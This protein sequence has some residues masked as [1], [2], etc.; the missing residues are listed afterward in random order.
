VFNYT[1]E[2][3]SMGLV[4][5][6]ARAYY[7]TMWAFN[8]CFKLIFDNTVLALSTEDG[9]PAGRDAFVGTPSSTIADGVDGASDE[10]WLTV[11]YPETRVSQEDGYFRFVSLLNATDW[12]KEIFGI[13]SDNTNSTFNMMP[14]PSQ[15]PKPQ[16]Y[17]SIGKIYFKLQPGKTFDDVDVKSVFGFSA[18]PPLTFLR[19]SGV[20]ISGRGI[21]SDAWAIADNGVIVK[22]NPPTGGDLLQPITSVALNV[23][24]PTAGQTASASF[25]GANNFT[26]KLSWVPS[27]STFKPGTVYTATATLTAN[28]GYTFKGLMPSNVTVNGQPAIV[29]SNSGNKLTIVYAFPKTDGETSEPYKIPGVNIS[30]PIND[31]SSG[32][33][34]FET[35]DYSVSAALTPKNT[36][37]VAGKTYSVS[38][39]LKAEA[40]KTFKGIN[41][42]AINGINSVAI[43]DV[44]STAINEGGAVA[45]TSN[46]GTTLTILYIFTAR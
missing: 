45:I 12:A 7:A 13:G 9:Q 3:E 22:R 35:W 27:G 38:I 33:F 31:M 26:G 42:V 16:E 34:T 17:L 6:E 19:T 44:K 39:T 10:T 46:T 30:V 8:F 11:F 20:S 43:N 14:P 32:N 4:S 25:T 29:S 18:D 28:S 5:L 24:T 1:V 36:P 21:I 41:D 37:L 15:L 2:S 23:A 40:G